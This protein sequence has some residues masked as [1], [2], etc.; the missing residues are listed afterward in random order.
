MRP[1]QLEWGNIGLVRATV[2]AR[3][4][5]FWEDGWRDL[6]ATTKENQIRGYGVL[7]DEKNLILPFHLIQNTPANLQF[8]YQQKWQDLNFL[9]SDQA[10]DLALFQL[11][12]PLKSASLKI[13]AD[14]NLGIFYHPEQGLKPG[15]KKLRDHGQFSD[16]YLAVEKSWS[17]LPL[18]GPKNCVGG[19]LSSRLGPEIS[20][21]I[22][23]NSLQSFLLE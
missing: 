21:F 8:Y 19:I 23:P 18:W 6:R 7:L 22:S 9:K 17:G 15:I 13:C 1:A 14:L 5:N 4:L 11:K 16:Y 2:K 12:S 3:P 10:K 20:R